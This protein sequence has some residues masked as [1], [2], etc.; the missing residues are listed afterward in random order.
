MAEISLK[1]Q[2]LFGGSLWPVQCT[3]HVLCIIKPPLAR[4]RSGGRLVAHIRST[5]HWM[6]VSALYS[7]AR[8]MK[9]WR[10]F[11]LLGCR[12]GWERPHQLVRR[13]GLVGT[14]T[15]QALAPAALADVTWLFSHQP[16]ALFDLLPE[17]R[18]LLLLEDR[19]LVP[20]PASI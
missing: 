9:M 8:N 12:A 20:D 5:W 16:P 17:R 4:S 1:N 10:L 11:L 14:C 6:H 13:G 19:I 15:S 18:L 3:V 2:Q 7:Q